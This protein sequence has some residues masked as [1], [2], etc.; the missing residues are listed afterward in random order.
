MVNVVAVLVL[1]VL[2]TFFGALW[3]S[4]LLFG[5]RWAKLARIRPGDFQ[6][7]SKTVNYVVAFIAVFLMMLILAFVVEFSGVGTFGEGLFIGILAWLG[8]IVTTMLNPVLW[9]RM[10][11]ELYVIQVMQYCILFALAGGILAVW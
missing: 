2:G 6:Q 4:H 5:K 1:A 7:S 11:F 9:E 8:F 3:Y 10:H